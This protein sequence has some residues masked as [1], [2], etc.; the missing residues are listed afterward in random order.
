MGQ[1][2]KPFL[3]HFECGRVAYQIN[4]KEVWEQNA[5]KTFHLAHTPDLT[6]WFNVRYLNCSDKFS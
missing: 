4:G 3:C 1:T 2:V 5:R 6:G